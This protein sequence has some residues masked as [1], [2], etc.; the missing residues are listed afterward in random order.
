MKEMM[1]S[2]AINFLRENYT[3]DVALGPL[4]AAE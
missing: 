4:R 1:P 2:R 3:T